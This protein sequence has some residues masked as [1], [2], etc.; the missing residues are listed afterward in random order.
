MAAFD[1]NVITRRIG[2]DQFR[3]WR[4]RVPAV[5]APGFL[6]LKA[7]HPHCWYRFLHGDIC[8]S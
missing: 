6:V 5:E 3:V 1:R 8:E 2:G 7:H 4:H